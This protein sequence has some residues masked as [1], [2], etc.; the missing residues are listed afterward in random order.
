MGNVVGGFN[1]KH[2]K[3]PYLLSTVTNIPIVNTDSR[4]GGLIKKET[5][6]VTVSFK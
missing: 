5:R 3:I 6:T 1:I 4:E 2:K